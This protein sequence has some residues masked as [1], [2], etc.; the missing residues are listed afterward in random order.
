[1]STAIEKVPGIG[2]VT[3]V[4]LATHG[5]LNAEDLASRRNG[6]LAAVKG[7]N[8]I[9]AGQVIEAARLLTGATGEDAS[10]PPGRSGKKDKDK[11]AE[12][13]KKKSKEKSKK[14][15]KDLKKKSPKEDNKTST[16]ATKKSSPKKGKDK[17]K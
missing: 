10:V 7:F 12:Q 5:I 4:V 16:K 8:I 9:R 3:A 2:P 14:K 13:K 11:K 15:S 6:D 17:K 1:M